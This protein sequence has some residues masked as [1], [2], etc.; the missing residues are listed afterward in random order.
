LLA[1]YPL[2]P[3]ELLR[4]RYDRVYKHL[5][6]LAESFPEAPVWLIKDDEMD[7]TNLSAIS[8]QDKDSLADAIVLLPPFV[9]G[10]SPSGMLADEPGDPA[11]D[12]ADEW[13]TDDERA[14]RRRIRVMADDS[15]LAE[16][17]RGMRL[18]RTIVI[19]GDDEEESGDETQKPREWC[20]YVRPQSADDDGSGNNVGKEILLNLHNASVGN[21]AAKFASAL[22][23][24]DT[25]RTALS[26]AGKHHDDG[27]DCKPWQRS[28][29]NRTEEVWAKSGNKRPPEIRLDYRHEFGSLL[30]VL[31]KSEFE[32]LT[33]EAQELAL[34]LIAAHHGRARP[35]F[36][37]K[38]AFDPRHP[39]EKA[40]DVAL[41][42]PR[43]FAR[44]QRKYGRWGL[45]YLESLLRAADAYASANPEAAA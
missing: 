25:I 26:F 27:K 6:R 22:G 18:I 32:S 12:V 24:D 29:G 33:P 40:A 35:H 21:V 7:I 20:W 36:S 37:G 1:D 9:G 45:A 4:D 31:G 11:L 19:G 38:E 10:L 23:L 13:F 42:V 30:D 43:R 28:I 5:Q 15:E 41:K 44:L 16:K 17:T 34:H 39:D 14:Q 3:H 2:K 8:V